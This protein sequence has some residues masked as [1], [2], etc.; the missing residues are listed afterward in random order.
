M[1]KL[2]KILGLCLLLMSLTFDVNAQKKSK[3][4]AKKETRIV[5]KKKTKS[6][7]SKKEN[8]NEGEGGDV[9]TENQQIQVG[10]G[11][12]SVT[13]DTTKPGELTITSS[14]KPSLRSAAKINFNATTPDLDT[15]KLSLNYNI[16]AQNLFFS[17]QP[18]AIKPLSLS[19]DSSF[20]WQNQQ[21]IKAGFGNYSTPYVETGLAFGHPNNTLLNIKANYVSSKGNIAFQEFAKANFKASASFGSIANHELVTSIGYNFF[22][23]YK[24]G[25]DKSFTP[26]K[27]VDKQS[28]NNVDLVAIFQNKLPNSYGISYKPQL[29]LNLFADDNK[30]TETSMIFNAPITKNISEK[31]NFTITANADI[32]SYKRDTLKLSNNVFSLAPSLNFN[33]KIL[34]VNLGAKPSWNNNEFTFL[35]NVFAE[36]K[37]ASDKIIVGA[38]WQGYFTK[39]T[40][41]SLASFNPFIEQPTTLL[42][43]KVSEQYVAVKGSIGKHFSFN[44]QLSFLQYTNKALFVNDDN[45]LNSQTFKT[46]YE[47]KLNALKIASEIGYTEKEK[48]SII[49]SF[50]VLQ[51]SGQDSFP[52]AYGIVP[53][54]LTT[55]V[56]YKILKD[57]FLKADMFLSTGNYYRVQTIQTEKTDAAFDLNIGAEY[58]ILNKLNLYVDF[59]NLFNNQYQRWHQY[60]VLGL[61][62]VAGV[63]YSFH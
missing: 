32:T 6:K 19:A 56:K 16:P 59:N 31:L 10:G 22:S 2:I 36:Y 60:Q 47:P 53:M 40:Y 7:K 58:K 15:T 13:K 27:P 5:S 35:P 8:D 48:L 43:T 34:L 29:A 14:F 17:Y 18:V 30:A 23:Q 45:S 46:L 25:V 49:S 3:K 41:K 44:S 4:K 55:T 28:F 11:N 12:A 54:E 51:F 37:L 9:A 50:S 62:V 42:N 21:Y 39:N 1:N 63:V 24:Y 26:G 57:I 52:K 38:G 20:E 61:N 33:N